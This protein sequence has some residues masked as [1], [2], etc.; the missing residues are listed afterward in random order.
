MKTKDS[1]VI[2]V[3]ADCIKCK[4]PTQHLVLK[5]E[6]ES[7]FNEY[8]DWYEIDHQIVK[9]AGCENV[10]YRLSIMTSEETDENGRSIEAVSIFPNP[11]DRKEIEYIFSLPKHVRSLYLETLT[12]LNA[13]AL[14]LA[15]AG[16]RAVV[17]A[18]CLNQGCTTHD[19]KS[20]IS[21]L[22][23]KGVLLERDAQYL[24]QHRFLGNE[25]VHE[26]EYPPRAEF[27]I[28]LKI[29][30]HLLSSVYVMPKM[31]DSLVSLRKA[32][33]AQVQ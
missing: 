15:A 8:T 33:G 9:C 11:K 30:E 20:K 14:T 29:L 21:E 3:K 18:T 26:L 5:S 12:A 10:C 27:E 13:G 24:H 7:G 32:R 22:V 19:L 4:T 17:E 23:S 1:S 25:A 2:Q 6:V 31:A 16:L 28:A